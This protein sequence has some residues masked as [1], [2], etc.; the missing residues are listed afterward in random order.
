MKYCKDCAHG[1]EIGPYALCASPKLLRLDPVTGMTEPKEYCHLTRA[2]F[3]PFDILQG[4]CGR[5]A[6]WFKRSE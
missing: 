6:R 3:W 1:R 4:D 5:R 2:T